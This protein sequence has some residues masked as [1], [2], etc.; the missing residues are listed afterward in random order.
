MRRAGLIVGLYYSYNPQLT[1]TELEELYQKNYKRTL[2]A[3]YNRKDIK[4][5]LY[6][7]GILMN[8]IE[9]N[10]PEYIAV[11]NELKNK[12][13]I[14]ILS[15]PYY[16]ALLPLL[17]VSDSLGPKENSKKKDKGMLDS[18]FSLGSKKYF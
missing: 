2:T 16:E 17:N 10:H 11:L 18:W 1:S 9:K 15:G 4:L 6:Y 7:S 3:V 5:V 13:R 14:E 8:W 12:K